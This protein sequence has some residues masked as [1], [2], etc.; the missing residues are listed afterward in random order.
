[1]LCTAGGWLIRDFERGD[2]DRFY[3]ALVKR[4]GQT[5][6]LGRQAGKL[7]WFPDRKVDRKKLLDDATEAR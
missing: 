6:A 3:K 5:T 1:M 2:A 4:C 7:H